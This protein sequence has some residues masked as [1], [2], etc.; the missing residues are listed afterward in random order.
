MPVKPSLG[1][2]ISLLGCILLALTPP[3]IRA[4]GFAIQETTQVHPSLHFFPDHPAAGSPFTAVVRLRMD[5]GWHTY[6]EF[7][8]D[9]GMPTSIEWQLPEGYKSA[10]IQWPLPQVHPSEGDQLTY[11]Y[12]NEVLLFTEI[13][14][15][16]AAAAPSQTPVT[17][18]AR[19]RWLACKETCI[20][21][22]GN[23]SATV[24]SPDAAIDP[25]LLAKWR[26]QLPQNSPPPFKIRWDKTS[27]HIALSL[28]GVA[29][30]AAVEFLPL[31][32]PGLSAGHPEPLPPTPLSS[33]SAR[34]SLEGTPEDNRPWRALVIVSAPGSERKGWTVSDSNPAKNSEA[35]ENSATSPGQTSVPPTAPQ[36]LFA[37]LWAAFLG[38]L[39][40][41]LMPCVLPV[42]ALK[43][44]GFVQ[45]AGESPKKVFHLGIAFVAGVFTFFL[46]LAALVSGFQAAGHG[47][48][49]GFQFQDSRILAALIVLVLVFALSMFGVFEITLNSDTSTTMD[50]WARKEGYA[51]AF[52]HGLFTTLLGTSCTA[53]LLGP[54]L[55]FAFTQSAPVIFSVFGMIASGMSLPYFLLTWKPAW[56][57]FLPKPGMWMERL[58][59]FMGFVLLAVVLW[60]VGVFG[61]THG[62]GGSTL[63]SGFLLVVALCAW[64]Y[65]T[66]RGPLSWV[67]ILLLLIAGWQGLLS[68]ALKQTAPSSTTAAQQEGIAW[69]NFSPQA[70]EN[71]LANG[72]PVFID[73]TAKWCLNCKYNERFV[74]ETEPVRTALRKHRVLPLKAD[75]THKD[76]EITAL[77]QKFGRVG[78]PAYVLYPGSPHSEPKVLPEILTQTLV[79]EAL[80]R[81]P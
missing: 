65:G 57:R 12:E 50:K 10:P 6:W 16:P 72:T 48:T 64:I 20:P 29:K 45:Q 62:S 17:L 30:D 21:G 73:F 81:L 22:Q 19:V 32:P 37:I 39:L 46:L 71:G 28:E 14:P 58:K 79:L 66:R 44:F 42:I 80:D 52:V 34:F 69:E 60:L 2:I 76:P 56:M 4:Q 25:A 31:P 7:G 9:S 77:L 38:G 55:G 53:P 40:L 63:L 35:S 23:V 70:L 68:T 67:W 75:W 1:W 3:P 78:V 24:G 43:I 13:T 49:W 54:V 5:P 74:L 41:N 59:Q 51:G 27:K 18:S 36:N 15:P 8:G 61:D 11:V 47:L 33:H 26:A